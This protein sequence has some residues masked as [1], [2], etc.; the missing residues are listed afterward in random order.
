MKIQQ[1]IR[2]DKIH[3]DPIYLLTKNNESNKYVFEICGSTKNVYKVQL[4]KKSK[5]IYCNCPDSKSYAKNYGVVCK[6][7]CFILLKVFKL[8]ES[9]TFFNLLF[10][11]DTQMKYIND[12]F[13]K[14]IFTENDFIKMEYID[15]FN[16][17]EDN[18]ICIQD[19]QELMCII[20]YD[21]LDDIKNISLNNQ[22]KK[23]YKI[24]HNKCLNKW[25]ALGNYTCPHCRTFIKSNY[26]KSLE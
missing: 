7:I 26:Y 14:L 6:H 13:N 20:C 10:F 2:I 8:I 4:Y 21:D 18:S 25:L 15:K 11:N 5:M 3:N 1:L 19:N 24:F 16:K 17:L 9:E 22:C 23:C 12:E